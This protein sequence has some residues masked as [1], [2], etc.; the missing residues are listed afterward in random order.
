MRL[1]FGLG[2]PG[3]LY[4][5]TRHNIGRSIVEKLARQLKIKFKKDNTVLCGWAKT[6]YKGQEI[7]VAFPLVFMNVCG[8]SLYRLTNKFQIPKEN[9]MVICD[10]LD[11]ELGKLRIRAKGGDGGHKGLRSIINFLQSN[12]FCRLRI[13]IGRDPDKEKIKDFVLST[14]NREENEIINEA[15][16]K[17]VECCLVW[18]AEGV[19]PAMNKFN[20]N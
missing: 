8:E 18:L 13:G 6:N 17:A 5:K 19:I 16:Q 10:D 20:K 2:N 15:K 12:D 7:I 14:F 3:I 4:Q 1:I 9:I 11:L